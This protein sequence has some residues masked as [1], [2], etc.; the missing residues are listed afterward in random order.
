MRVTITTKSTPQQ[1]ETF[2]P[3]A[4]V[5][6]ALRVRHTHED[7]KIRRMRNA[8]IVN[9]ENYA[10]IAILQ[11]TVR[12][13]VR[14]ITYRGDEFQVSRGLNDPDRINAGIKLPF[15]LVKE[16]TSIK[17]I[18]R[19][20]EMEDIDSDIYDLEDNKRVT[21]NKKLPRFP[22][23]EIIYVSGYAALP[24]TLE[25]DALRNAVNEMVQD[26]YDNPASARGIPK[27]A[28]QSLNP[29]FNSPLTK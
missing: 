16:I 12:C 9:A 15:P 10:R 21:W 17:G 5:K 29:F 4:D 27:S 26:A 19:E 20:G 8:A 11:K 25:W 14:G 18:P 23:Y 1:A 13:V 6:A 3:L 24:E 2:L 28:K 22:N 7:A